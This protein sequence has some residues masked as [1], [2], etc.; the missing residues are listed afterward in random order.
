MS[1]ALLDMLPAESFYLAA[2]YRH[3]YPSETTHWGQAGNELQ[4]LAV[5]NPDGVSVDRLSR[6]FGVP[7]PALAQSNTR[8]LLNVKPFPTFMNYSSR[9]LAESWDSTNLYWARLADEMGYSP[10]MLEPPDPRKIDHAHGGA[11]IASHLER[12]AR[13]RARHARDRRQISGRVKLPR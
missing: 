7:H 2:E 11:N 6:D 4:Q 3:R 13:N 10:E 1:D 9:L 5:R 8:E 12:L